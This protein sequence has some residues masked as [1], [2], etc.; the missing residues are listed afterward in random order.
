MSIVPLIVNNI[1]IRF[2]FHRS[3]AELLKFLSTLSWLEN[4]SVF[5][6]N[7]SKGCWQGG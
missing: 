6:L 3:F 2:A 4:L 1:R 7:D 5:N